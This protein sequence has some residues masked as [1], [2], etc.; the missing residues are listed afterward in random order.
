VVFTYVFSL[1][2]QTFYA[3][4]LLTYRPS[5]NRKLQ[6]GLGGVF[7][8]LNFDGTCKSTLRFRTI[9]GEG[10]TTRSG[11]VAHPHWEGSIFP[12]SLSGFL[13]IVKLTSYFNV[14]TEPIY[15]WIIIT[16]SRSAHIV[17]RVR[18]SQ[19]SG[20][21]VISSDRLSVR[22]IELEKRP[23]YV[24]CRSSRRISSSG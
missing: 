23:V 13:I 7:T 24:N 17:S 14:R 2:S 6:H 19:F 20:C 3:I 10:D 18:D 9:S 4:Y 21:L 8:T 16:S 15:T 1:D 11:C 22:Y 5:M 12:C